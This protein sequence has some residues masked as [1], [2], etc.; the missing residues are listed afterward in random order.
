M[1]NTNAL[2]RGPYKPGIARRLQVVTAAVEVFGEYGYAGGTVQRVADRVG[3]TPAA[4]D[5]LFGNKE[6][7]L[8]AVLEH[9]DEQTTEVIGP[10]ARGMALLDGFRALMAYHV[11]H[12]GLLELYTTMAAESTSPR[13]PAHAFMNERY[14]TSLTTMR[15]IFVDAAREGALRPMSD[16][17]AAL[18]AECLLATMD[19]LE[20]Q[21]LHNPDFDLERAFGRFL[22]QLI[23]R[24]APVPA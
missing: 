23:A 3:V 9:W 17:D 1:S 22:D 20:I 15:Q 18:E 8:V 14:R 24:L 21:F 11:R 19:G 2:V 16:E 4:I 10:D 5:K 12:K 7:L 13:H 6:A